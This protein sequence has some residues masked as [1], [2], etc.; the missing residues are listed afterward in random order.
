MLTLIIVSAIILYILIGIFITARYWDWLTMND[1]D[2]DLKFLF[3]MIGW[4]IWPIIL[5]IRVGRYFK[6]KD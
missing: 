6:A 1:N 3:S 4:M 2:N 5:A